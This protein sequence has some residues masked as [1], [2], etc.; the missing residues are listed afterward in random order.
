VIR[1]AAIEQALDTSLVAVAARLDALAADAEGELH[2]QGVT[3]GRSS[4]TDALT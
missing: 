1:E 2:R 4:C 3:G